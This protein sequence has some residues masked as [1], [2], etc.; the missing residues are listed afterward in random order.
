MF[1]GSVE[2]LYHCVTNCVTRS[3]AIL[4]KKYFLFIFFSGWS[5]R[6]LS[7]YMTIY[8]SN[9]GHAIKHCHCPSA[10][11][12]LYSHTFDPACLLQG[13]LIFLSQPFYSDVFM[14][15]LENSSINQQANDSTKF[16]QRCSPHPFLNLASK[17]SNNHEF[18]IGV[19]K[20]NVQ[21]IIRNKKMKKHHVGYVHFWPHQ[22]TREDVL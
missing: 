4:S 7:A 10:S 15:R 1:L 22:H 17:V 6:M 3:C 18:F 20:Y 19:C 12:S 2:S 11:C 16:I 14:W 9:V 21:N 13:K 8:C 5:L